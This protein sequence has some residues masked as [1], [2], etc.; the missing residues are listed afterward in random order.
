MVKK[1]A[2]IGFGSTMIG[3]GINGFIIP[4]HLINGGFLGISLILNYLWGFKAGLMFIFLNVP[5]YLFAFKSDPRYFIN[6][7]S[8]AIISGIMIEILMPLNGKFHLPIMSSVI[9]GAVFIGIGVGIMLRNHISPGGMDLLALLLSKWS[10]INVG[11]IIFALDMVVIMTGLLILQ[12]AKLFYSLLIIS[13]V[14]L[15]ASLI[16]SFHSVQIYLK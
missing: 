1:I 4:F 3:I 13:I 14:G 5:V 9:I 16:T 11:V 8:G 7:L 12:D 2:V 10:R 6:G 15:F